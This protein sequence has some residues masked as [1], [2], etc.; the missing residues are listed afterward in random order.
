M[1]TAE[2][3]IAPRWIGVGIR[4]LPL[5]IANM[6]LRR[7]T[8]KIVAGHPASFSRMA[9]Y[10]SAV[11]L[12]EPTDIPI[13]FRARLDSPTP[14]ICQRRP[15]ACTWDARIAGPISS[16]LAMAEGASDGDALFF[17]REINI[18][19]NTDAILALRNAIDDAELNLADE[20]AGLLGPL[21]PAAKRA[22]EVAMPI[23]RPLLNGSI[24][25]R[26][27]RST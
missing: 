20:I 23:I 5:P 8:T 19:G 16:L 2:R 12:I 10:A 11:F 4:A 6:M 27:V 18:E 25:I 15:T 7:L 17:S 22:I 3:A 14:V 13:Q 24:A 9:P 26:G 1:E 21:R